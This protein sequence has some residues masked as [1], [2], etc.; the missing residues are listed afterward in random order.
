MNV[1]GALH[2]GSETLKAAALST[3]APMLDAEVLL[4]A[5]VGMPKSWMFSHLAHDMAPHEEERYK[6]FVKRRAAHEPV[7]YILGKKEFFGRTFTITSDTLIPRPDTEILVE[8]AITAS[9]DDSKDTTLFADIGTGSGAIGVTLAA[10]TGIPVV[11]TDI[12][13]AAATIARE[14]AKALD[15]ETL[16]DVRVGHLI[17][18]LL[19]IFRALKRRESAPVEHVIIC[20][21]LPYLTSRQV[22]EGQEDVREFEPHSALIG[23]GD[24][25]LDLYRDLVRSLRSARELLPKHVTLLCEI[26]PA[27]RDGIRTLVRAAFPHAHP[28]ILEDLGGLDRVMITDV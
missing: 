25:G 6:E 28:R 22:E 4:S 2:W 16:V 3:D 12:H 7:A 24:D 26:D 10:E 11:A 19:D 21:N 9:T 8:A 1:L 20:A 14:N 5:A 27:Q 18:P 17:D 13:E 23:G 15:C